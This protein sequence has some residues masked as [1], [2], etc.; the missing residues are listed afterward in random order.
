MGKPLLFYLID[1]H[2]DDIKYCEQKGMVPCKF[3][4]KELDGKPYKSA[5]QYIYKGYIY[6]VLESGQCYS[7]YML[8]LMRL[9]QPSYEQLLNVLLNS[10]HYEE[11]VGATGVILKHYPK[12]FERS[13]TSIINAG[14]EQSKNRK[15]IKRMAKCVYNI[16]NDSCYIKQFESIMNLCKE[17]ELLLN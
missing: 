17:I 10:K 3:A 1:E 9:P 7:G 5:I 13:L 16:I 4:D 12:E 2:T 15:G 11:R 14:T 8:T 6:D